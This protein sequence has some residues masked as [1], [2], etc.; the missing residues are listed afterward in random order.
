MKLYAVLGLALASAACSSSYMRDAAPSGPPKADEAKIVV[1]RSSS[2]FGGA[3]TFPVYEGEKLLGFAEK[4]CFFEYR[5]PPGKRVFVSWGENEKVVE[6]AL[7]AGKTYY[8]NAYPKV[9]AWTS[10][11]GL[12]P[13]TMAHGDWA[14]VEALVAGLS[15]REVIPEKAAQ[16]E[17]KR[18]EKARKILQEHAAGEEDALF[19]KAE[20]GK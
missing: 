16:H 17:E 18:R 14:G 8:L 1:Y 15:C 9:G 13:V 6:A 19:L 3:V 7:S 20:D 11:V 4:G 2:L 12:D 10:A 5:C